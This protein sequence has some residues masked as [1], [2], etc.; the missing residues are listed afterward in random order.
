MLVRHAMMISLV[1]VSGVLGTAGRGAIT[2]TVAPE[3]VVTL[4]VPGRSSANPTIAVSGSFV[5]V[6]WSAATTNAMDIF[7]ATSRDGGRSF[8]A[9]VQVNAVAGDARVSGEEPPR[10]AL[11]PRGKSEPEVVV[12]WTAK[13]GTNWRLIHARSLDGGKTFGASRAVPGSEADGS[14]GWQSVNVDATG[15]VNVLWLDHRELVAATPMHQ[16]D[17]SKA[18][19]AV[20]PPVKADPTSRAALSQLYFASLDGT[21]AVS[22]THSVCYCCK[23][24]L[25][26]SGNNVFA[27]WRHVYAGSFRD[28]AFSMSRDRGRTFST[29][30][31]VSEDHW[32]LDGCPDN[33]PSIAIDATQRAHVVWPASQDGKDAASLAVFYAT[34][35]DG[36][37]FTARTRIPTRGP[38]SHP[39]IVIGRDGTPIVSWDEIIDGAR[40]LGL[41]RV[42][43][44]AAGM[45]TFTMIT[46]PD[47]GVGQWYT[48]LAATDRGA[49]MTWVRQGDK[50][51]GTIGVAHVQ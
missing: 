19:A 50:G 3:P 16:Y 20:A 17:T 39:Q 13:T 21:S 12:V 30:V 44:D 10:V 8:T 23:T 7:V 18:A 27:V 49:M 48:S 6:T 28:I 42:R 51:G 5:A 14:R 2:H 25:A 34:S 36:K 38:A 35:R 41:A 26:S 29:P 9:P 22:I 37:A 33:G 1:A 47:A 46:P 32:Q 45:P 11:V 43:V 4:A 15:R 40:R 31:R 24:T